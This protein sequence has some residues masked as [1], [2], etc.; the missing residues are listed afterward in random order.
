MNKTKELLVEIDV[1]LDQILDIAARLKAISQSVIA[2]EEVAG[3]QKAQEELLQKLLALEEEHKKED[4]KIADPSILDIQKTIHQKLELFEE[5][6]ANFIENLSSRRKP[7][8]LP[9]DHEE[10]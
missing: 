2:K 3:L 1:V 6:N 10:K 8:S 4:P 9:T 7:I 5:L